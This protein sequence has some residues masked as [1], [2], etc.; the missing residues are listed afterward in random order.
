MA[1]CKVFGRSWNRSS[2]YNID[3]N[4]PIRCTL[5]PPE[6]YLDASLQPCTRSDAVFITVPPGCP[7]PSGF[8]YLRDYE[9]TPLD[10]AAS[11]TD[12]NSGNCEENTIEDEMVVLSFSPENTE[13]ALRFPFGEGG[14]SYLHSFLNPSKAEIDGPMLSPTPEAESVSLR[15]EDA[16]K[17]G[18][19]TSSS[20]AILRSIASDAKA[21]VTPT[22]SAQ[23][24]ALNGDA[25]CET[26]PFII[27][28]AHDG[29][30]ALP[31]KTKKFVKATNFLVKLKGIKHI[32]SSN[33][34]GSDTQKIVFETIFPFRS[35]KTMEINKGDFKHILAKIMEDCPEAILYRNKGIGAFET[36]F[37]TML[38][39]Q[40]AT[41][42]HIFEFHSSGWRV[43][44][45]GVYFYVE[46][47]GTPPDDY[48]IYRSGFS[49]RRGEASKSEAQIVQAGWGI[50]GL[51][52]KSESIAIPFLFAHLGL[53]FHFFESAG[54]APRALL[55]IEG[56]TGSLKTAVSALL[57]N[58][59]GVPEQNIPATFRDTAASL[60]IKF[61][62]YRDRILLVDD[63]CPASDAGSRRAME[64]SLEQLVRF[65]GD[66][67][68]KGR[69]NPN[70]DE[71]K[72]LK[73]CGLV[74][75]TGEDSA[76]SQSSLLRCLFL[77]I[78][79]DTF[80]K[81]LL[82]TYQA[83]P[84]LW[85]E[86]L[87]WFVS[88]L[89]PHAVEVI[90][91]IKAYFQRYRDIGGR[92][93]TE[94]RLIDT[95][96]CL[97]ITADIVTREVQGFLSLEPDYVS[98][99]QVDILKVCQAS[100]AR[101]KTASPV[102]IFCQALLAL[103]AQNRIHLAT[104]VAE[105]TDN[106]GDYLGVEK[107]GFWFL[108][109]QDTYSV[110]SKAYQAIGKTFPKSSNALFGDLVSAGVL[111]PYKS[112]RKDG[113]DRIEYGTKVGFGDRPRLLKVAPERLRAIA[114]SEE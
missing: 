110:I 86:Y 112:H 1:V 66:G 102:R 8:T 44:P 51:A 87:A 12:E 27:K 69:A 25:D 22:S 72:E 60:E 98:L 42:P 57:F 104:T 45:N 67:I 95:Y 73:P 92:Y 21:I 26:T 100:E 70:M 96:A 53:L 63:F 88:H 75:I 89:A 65:F 59:S 97:A 91:Y 113:I 31:P 71:V 6:Q 43:T 78:E 54:C 11:V 46:D 106:P 50:L 30:Y 32:W 64:S 56:P 68:A 13:A 17:D 81:D 109:P 94:K 52:K 14:H 47:N 99:L 76:G 23:N 74:A 103:M 41:V 36:E 24:V 85:T 101:T 93:L 111:I 79:K 33:D 16:G 55:F 37:Q 7:Y 105:F 90:A 39:E 9:Y 107:D 10:E 3:P 20:P 5:Y 82:R 29:Y 58:F 28:E 114:D 48:I 19:N 35:A 49:F 2:N 61:A 83:A 62:K 38:R 84:G 77:S 108:W 40:V 34:A 18:A 80:D 15:R 4:I